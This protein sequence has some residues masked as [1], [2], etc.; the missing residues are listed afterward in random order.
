MLLSEIQEAKGTINQASHQDSVTG[1]GG[2][3]EINFGGH[4][5]FIY[6]NSRRAWGHEKFIR[7]WIKQKK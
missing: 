4:K 1:G 5:K 6:M 3:K 2:R 7:V